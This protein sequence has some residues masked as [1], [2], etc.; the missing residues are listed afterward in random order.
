MYG[1]Y[2]SS[3]SYLNVTGSVSLRLSTMARSLLGLLPRSSKLSLTLD[4]PTSGYPP[5]SAIGRTLHAVRSFLFFLFR[6]TG[7]GIL[8]IFPHLRIFFSV[9]PIICSFELSRNA[10][11]R[12]LQNNPNRASERNAEKWLTKNIPNRASA[13][14]TSEL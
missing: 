2:A 7:M 10:E 3:I 9:F 4:P 14:R 5:R 6:I 8:R 13:P 11:K 12:C 1:T